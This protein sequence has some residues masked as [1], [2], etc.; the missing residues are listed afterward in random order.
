MEAPSLHEKDLY[1]NKGGTRGF[2]AARSN[3]ELENILE[4]KWGD[5][6][7][8]NGDSKEEEE[9][10]GK[11]KAIA[12]YKITLFL[13]SFLYFNIQTYPW[14]GTYEG[15]CTALR[16]SAVSITTRLLQDHFFPCTITVMDS[17]KGLGDQNMDFLFGLDMLKRHRCKIDLE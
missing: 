14:T 7:G 9:T 16:R 15:G 3:A 13:F 2:D 10:P 11:D 17:E 6:D 12:P 1:E 4:E 8:Q 5:E